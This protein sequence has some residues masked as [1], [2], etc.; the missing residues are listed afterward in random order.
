MVKSK[1]DV[2]CHGL[3]PVSSGMTLCGAR[4]SGPRC[5]YPPEAAGGSSRRQQGRT[6]QQGSFTMARS[7][8]SPLCCVR[9]ASSA[10]LTLCRA[11]RHTGL[12]SPARNLITYPPAIPLPATLRA[13]R[14]LCA[15]QLPAHHTLPARRENCGRLGCIRS[16]RGCG[17]PAAVANSAQA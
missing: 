4:Q 13:G 5:R 14:D 3:P 11:V 15:L 12:P 9:P 10:G 6:E 16:R 17:R 1:L 7:S 8:P 2:M